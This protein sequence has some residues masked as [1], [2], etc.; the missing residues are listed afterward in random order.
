MAAVPPPTG[1]P[2]DHEQVNPCDEYDADQYKSHFQIL[3]FCFLL[4]GIYPLVVLETANGRSALAGIACPD[5]SHNTRRHLS[6]THLPSNPAAILCC[7][8][9]SSQ[10]VSANIF[11]S[12][13]ACCSV[14]YARETA[15]GSIWS[16]ILGPSPHAHLP[17]PQQL[18]GVAPPRMAV[19]GQRR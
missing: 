18:V 19:G 9:R 1:R 13:S 7:D 2:H 16:V 12:S 4:H 6:Q 3:E 11:S 10:S 17:L 5:A 8:V 15:L 14:S